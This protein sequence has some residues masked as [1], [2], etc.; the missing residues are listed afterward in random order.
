[1]LNNKIIVS[2]WARRALDA[3]HRRRAVG[4]WM[5][6]RDPA[7]GPEGFYRPSPK[8]ATEGLERGHAAFDMFVLHD[9]WC[10]T[11]WVSYLISRL[12]WLQLIRAR[13]VTNL[14]IWRNPCARLFPTS[15]AGL[16]AIKL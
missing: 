9:S 14:T 6:L 1:M 2:F 5:E 10:D 7:R 15:R 16:R 3:I 8:V 12:G 4:A 13:Y 11:D